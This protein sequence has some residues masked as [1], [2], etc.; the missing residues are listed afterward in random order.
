M[1][2]DLLDDEID[3]ALGTAV[4]DPMAGSDPE[5]PASDLG[6]DLGADG[7]DQ[8]GGSW[9]DQLLEVLTRSPDKSIHQVDRSEYFDPE[10]GGINRLVLVADDAVTNGDG[11]QNWMHLCI[12]MAE[13][14]IGEIDVSNES[15]DHESHES[16]GTTLE[17]TDTSELSVA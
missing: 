12:A 4:D 9:D 16:S 11:L 1:T 7:V 2:D 14:A 13:I 5:G 15:A 3:D 10:A 8:P 17:E 6:A